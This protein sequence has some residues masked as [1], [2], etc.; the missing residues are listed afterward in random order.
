M[1]TIINYGLGN[2]SAFENIYRS[3]NISTKIACRPDDLNDATHILLP[4]V[5]SFDKAISLL[6]GSC[7][8]DAIIEKIQDNVNLLGICIGMHVLGTRSDEGHLQGLNVIPGVVRK[9]NHD[10]C[11]IPHM[12]WNNISK[13]YDN[14]LMRGISS[15]DYFYFLHSYAFIPESTSSIISD[16]KYSC[17]FVSGI[18]KGNIYGIQ[19]HPEKSHKSGIKLLK[20]FAEI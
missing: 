18:N 15:Q 13:K 12:G 4:G 20:N 5:G 10:N 1:I 6:E 19:F 14:H 7:L 8:K 3:I 9:I 17:E 16:T 2:V 11:L